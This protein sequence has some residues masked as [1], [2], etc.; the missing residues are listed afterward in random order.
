MKIIL[1]W[2]EDIPLS[3][4]RLSQN[5][6]HYN[7]KEIESECETSKAKQKVIFNDKE[8]DKKAMNDEAFEG[9]TNF[10]FQCHENNFLMLFL[11]IDLHFK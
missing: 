3:T 1:L 8:E 11:T 2:L 5:P 4:K 7:S 6:W 10:H 9:F